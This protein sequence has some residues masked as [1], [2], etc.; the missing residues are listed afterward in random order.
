MS[1]FL[2]KT[3]NVY[4]FPLINV[5]IQHSRTALVTKTS[6]TGHT[7]VLHHSSETPGQAN[8]LTKPLDYST[9]FS[10]AR[11]RPQRKKDSLAITL[12]FQTSW[13]KEIEEEIQYRFGRFIQQAN[14]ERLKL[15]LWELRSAVHR[16]Q[17]FTS[18]AKKKYIYS[19]GL[20]AFPSLTEYNF[21]SC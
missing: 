15:G 13:E 2:L 9:S 7:G 18:R 20:V 10:T 8:T 12:S 4:P 1:L 16:R 5:Y 19:E 6:S 17:K 11:F 3:T 21:F 14:R